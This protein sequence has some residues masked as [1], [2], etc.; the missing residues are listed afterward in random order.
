M[1]VEILNHI[2]D[3]GDSDYIV[4]DIISNNI[5]NGSFGYIISVNI[6]K[7]SDKMSSVTRRAALKISK[8]VKVV[9]SDSLESVL[10]SMNNEIYFSKKMSLLHIGP[11]YFGSSI[12]IEEDIPT[13]Y[14][15]M[16]LCDKNMK[17]VIINQEDENIVAS[18][19]SNMCEIIR[20]MV[21]EGNVSCFDIKPENFVYCNG[22]I[23]MIDFDGRFCSSISEKKDYR[24]LYNIS[25]LILMI[26]TL[27]ILLSKSNPD[28]YI[29]IISK[30]FMDIDGIND[31]MGSEG[32]EYLYN[33]NK[34]SKNVLDNYTE[35]TY[36]ILDPRY[37]YN[38]IMGGRSLN[39]KD[40]ILKIL[41]R[42]TTPSRNPSF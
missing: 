30:I 4:K 9:D 26:T 36:D 25:I 39:T 12:M 29:S 7:K 42:Y 23:C 37:S 35:K 2:F 41:H 28:K 5:G 32:I 20:K 11:E 33:Y 34:V 13:L 15:L 40:M 17:N 38:L 10:E 31:L 24:I 22:D 27:E 8:G 18:Y 6:S 19:I 14:I 16:G 21:F 3:N 1:N